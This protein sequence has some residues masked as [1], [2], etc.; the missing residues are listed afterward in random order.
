LCFLT[1]FSVSSILPNLL[2]STKCRSQQI[3]VEVKS[4]IKSTSHANQIKSPIATTER[5]T[6]RRSLTGIQPS[7]PNNSRRS[8]LGGVK[9][10]PVACKLNLQ[11]CHFF[12]FSVIWN[13]W[14]NHWDLFGLE[15]WQVLIW[16]SKVSNIGSL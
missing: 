10:V 12:H 14:H 5:T 15:K 7:G 4:P 2:L 8:S 11:N 9:P 16:S 3:N 13:S 1:F 6:R